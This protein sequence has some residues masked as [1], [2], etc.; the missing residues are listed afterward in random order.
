MPTIAEIKKDR[1]FYRNFG[2]LIEVLKGIAVAHF[3]AL[4]KR[5]VRFEEFM[6][7]LE[8]FFDFLDLAAIAHPFMDPKDAPTGVVAVTSDAGLLG[9]LN[10][11]VMMAAISYLKNAKN[12]LIVVGLQGQKIAQ[13]YKIPCKTFT[14]I[15]DEKRYAWAMEIRDYIVDEALNRRIGPVKV[16]YPFAIS[17]KIQQVGELNL[18]PASEWKKEKEQ[19]PAA[20]GGDLMLETSPGDMLEYLINIWL[21]QKIFDVLQLSRLAEFAARTIHLEESSQRVKDIDRK[22]QL[23]YFRIRHEIIDQQMRE[24]FTARSLFSG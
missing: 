16:I 5:I 2:S 4:E 22:L 14:G 18:L 20:D 6:Q 1:E 13:G 7:I 8:G 23:R 15:I 12:K 10:H 11:R 3:H 21:G 19:K 17:V 24:L 9:G